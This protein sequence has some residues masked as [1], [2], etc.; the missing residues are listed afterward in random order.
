MVF[1]YLRSDLITTLSR[2]QVN[3][4]PHIVYGLDLPQLIEQ[5]QISASIA[6]GALFGWMSNM[7]V[8]RSFSTLLLTLIKR[9]LKKSKKKKPN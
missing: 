4:F 1:A 3:D 9:T 5:N 7:R 2:L 6:D 8:Q